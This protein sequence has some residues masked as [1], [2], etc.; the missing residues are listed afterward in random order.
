MSEASIYLICGGK[1]H[2]FAYVQTELTTHLDKL[3]ISCAGVAED[4]E[5][6]EAINGADALLTYTADLV[7]TA[8]G[9]SA[10]DGFMARGG[11]WFALHGTNS[12]I[13][14]DDK[15]YAS[16]SKSNSTFMQ[17]L[18]SQFMAHPPKGEFEVHN[19]Q[20]EH[21]L[22]SGIESFTV[23]DELYLIEERGEIDVLLYSEFSGKAMR[24]FKE[25]DYF[26][27]EPRRPMLY[28]RK[29][30]EGE[31]LYFNLGHCRGHEDM[32]PLMDYY[33]E[34][35]RCAWESPVFREI[36]DRGLNWAVS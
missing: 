35:E 16:S 12:I 19:A 21:P 15:G 7:P 2:D 29:W 11:R 34:I 18:G 14:I 13:D 30:H 24:G 28:L 23:E 17:I 3:G 32:K 1:Y 22:V 33:P 9:E 5:D 20:P 10:L 27:D 4:Y 8:E 36:I 31:V 26:S 25:R 6:A